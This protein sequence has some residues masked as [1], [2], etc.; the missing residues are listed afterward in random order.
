M[1]A[2]KDFGG[3]CGDMGVDL[4]ETKV[5]CSSWIAIYAQ[6]MEYILSHNIDKACEALFSYQSVLPG[7][8]SILR[9]DAIKDYPIEAFL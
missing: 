6:Y 3:A 9:W 8:F 2:N 5:S 1:W 4:N 7:A